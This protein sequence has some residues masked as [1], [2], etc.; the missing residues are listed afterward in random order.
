MWLPES[1]RQGMGRPT[2]ARLIANAYPRGATFYE[3][4]GAESF[5]RIC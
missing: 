2:C 3:A 1:P 5:A 4:F